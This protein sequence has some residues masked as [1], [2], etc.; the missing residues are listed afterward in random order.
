VQADDGETEKRN[1]VLRAEN[2]LVVHVN[3]EEFVEGLDVAD[4]A[5]VR[6]GANNTVEAGAAPGRAR[7]IEAEGAVGILDGAEIYVRTPVARKSDLDARNLFTRDGHNG[8]EA[9]VND[10]AG[11]LQASKPARVSETVRPRLEELDDFA[12]HA[13]GDFQ[14]I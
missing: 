3:V 5:V 12:A 4:A 9:G 6:A 7:R 11:G 13:F 2:A 1:G 10:V 14:G 8:I